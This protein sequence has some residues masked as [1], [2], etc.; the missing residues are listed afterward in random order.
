MARLTDY[1]SY[2]DAHRHFSKAALWDLFDGNRECLN[3]A[4]ECVD[5]HPRSR[6]AIRI[7]HDDGRSELMTF[8]ALSDL[9]GQ[10]AAWLAGRGVSRGDPVAIMLEPSPLFYAALFGTMK[11]GAVAVPLFTAFG[12]DGLAARLA[13]CRP[14]LLL[15]APE[16]RALAAAAGVT[17]VIADNRFQARIEREDTRF[18]VNTTSSDMAMLQ[19]TSGTSRELPEAV[20]HRHRAVVT[21]II[22][23]LYATGIRP[24]DRFMCPSSPAWGH[25]LWHGT[26][27]PLA[28]GVEIASYS[29][30]FDPDRLLAAIEKF[31]T[32]NLSAAATHYRMMRINAARVR[33]R[34]PIGKL[35]FTGEPLDTETAHWARSTFGTD[36]CS[37][38]GSTEVGVIIAAYPGAPDLPAKIGSLGKP[39]PGCDV[40]I[41]DQAGNR[42]P[43]DRVGEIM[44]RRGDTW[45]RVKD[46]GS[47]DADGYFFHHGRAD[48]AIISSGWTMSAVE[49][50]DVL[51]K[52]PDVL[53]VAAIGVPDED[54]GQIVKAFVV[55]SRVG[56]AAFSEELRTLAR[57]RLSRHEY[58]RQIAFVDALP[59][60]PAGKVNRKALRD[61]ENAVREAV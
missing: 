2:A 8:G 41:L 10:F 7:A 40:A 29:G 45:F 22:A 57:N 3:I 49:I 16:K 55:A 5:R 51:L 9:S 13:D 30:K 47:V 42:C 26:L 12:P 11:A 61:I 15:L 50:E 20:R 25:G 18:T 58:P 31:G 32:T 17:T 28:L 19:Y 39:L 54:R 52:H 38:Y 36:V 59:K 44:L 37:I 60:T 34:L 53:D 46:L 1:V 56:T 48:D 27:A 14:A 35:S 21:V 24:G 6:V 43:P 33:R 4:H 23:A